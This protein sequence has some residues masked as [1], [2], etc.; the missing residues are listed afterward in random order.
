MTCPH[1]GNSDIRRSQ[2]SHWSDAMRHALGRQAYRCRHCR[3][4]FYLPRFAPAATDTKA[5]SAEGRK[6]AKR[7]DFRK[8]KRLIR[9]LITIAVFVVMFSMFGLFLR[10][11]TEDRI[12]A[13]NPQGADSSDQ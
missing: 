4:R 3:L 1:C 10:H 2:S 9:R 12:P 5:E 11:I 13:N 6:T 8:R 7:P